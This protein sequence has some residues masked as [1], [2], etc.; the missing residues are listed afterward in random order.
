VPSLKRVAVLTAASFTTLVLAACG[1]KATPGDTV[2]KPNVLAQLISDATGS[3]R[4]SIDNTNKATSV[5]FTMTGTSAGEKME[6]EG[7]M[8]FG[9]PLKVDMTATDPKEGKTTVRIIGTTFYIGIPEEQ[10][11]SMDGKQWMKMDLGDMGAGSEA[12]SQQF[13]NMDPVKSIE[14]LLKG[15][16]VTVVGEDTVDGVKTVHYATTGSIDTYL[17]QLDATMRKTV[18][19]QLAKA[20]VTEVKTDVWV[21]EQYQPRRVHMVMG[22]MSDFTVNYT[23]YGTPVTV[24]VPPA[25]Q[26]VD[27]KEMMD[28][29]KDLTA[30]N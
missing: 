8:A 10:R 19:D 2:E 20:G 1:S 18:R 24:E 3:L 4:K 9:D 7:R 23:D 30:G 25:D 15:K 17:E 21:D 5:A 16:A 12:L 6:V 26:T 22:T 14:T 28:Q 13:D 29:L 11:A 27:F